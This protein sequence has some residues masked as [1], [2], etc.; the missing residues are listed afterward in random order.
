MSETKQ[1][2][3]ESPSEDV[4][5]VSETKLKR[6]LKVS[7]VME[8]DIKTFR[9]YIRSNPPFSAMKNYRKA[10][11][12]AILEEDETELNLK[13]I[14]TLEKA[15]RIQID[16]GI[17]RKR[18]KAGTGTRVA[19]TNVYKDNKNNRL[20]DRV[21]KEF[22]TYKWVDAEVEEVPVKLRRRKR[23]RKDTDEAGE[24]R[25]NLWIESVDQAKK[26]LDAPK[27][28]IIRKAPK[29]PENITP[30]DEISCKVYARA[31]EILAEK[32]AA[33]AQ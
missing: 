6:G 7:K 31:I 4:A 9:A 28:C 16:N 17:T 14:K 24:K 11:N 12:K 2:E 26:E 20:L 25:V 33:A 29:N 19:V 5:P 10:L 3:V 22:T 8:M 1:L 27:W 30:E 18:R 21:G 13:K 32:K 15:M 23:R